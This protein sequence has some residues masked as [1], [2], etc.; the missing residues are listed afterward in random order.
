MT[1]D[2]RSIHVLRRLECERLLATG[3]IGRVVLTDRALPVAM[4]VGYT[5]DGSD[6]VFRTGEGNKLA[7]ARAGMVVAFEVDDVDVDR[8]VGWSVLVTG[9]ARPV[10]DPADI[11]RVSALA[12][13]DW[14]GGGDTTFVRIVPGLLSGRRI[15]GAPDVSP[16]VPPV[17]GPPARC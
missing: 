4:P 11:A 16:A 12:L 5:L 10:T 1:G 8:R 13:P 3:R 9:V 14:V 2:A 15:T 6:I 7:A 17:A